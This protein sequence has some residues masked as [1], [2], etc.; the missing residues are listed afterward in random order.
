M[1]L[2]Q[3]ETVNNTDTRDGYATVG[4]QNMRR[5]D[6]LLYTY[7]NQYAAGAAPLATGRAILF[8]PLGLALVPDVLVEPASFTAV[9]PPDEQVALTLHIANT[10]P[11]GSVLGYAIDTVD[12]ATLPPVPEPAGG[13]SGSPMLDILGSTMTM[14]T[15]TYEAGTTVDIEAT[16]H[17]EGPTGILTVAR[18]QMPAG[19]TLNQATDFLRNGNSTLFWLGQA[20]EG[21]LTSWDGLNGEWVYYIPPGQS[22]TATLDLSFGAG[23]VGDLSF[24]YVLEDIG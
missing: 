24:Q 11:E 3:Y 8:L 1:I 16:I 15:A 14:D 7:W 23:L 5:T 4:I 2:F 13:D 10:G 6:G 12:P 20:G 18:L 9:L 17:A 19:V 21:V 22:A